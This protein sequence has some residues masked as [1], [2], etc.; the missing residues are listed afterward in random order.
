MKKTLFENAVFYMVFAHFKKVK[1]YFCNE[2]LFFTVISAHNEKWYFSR[3]RK[4]CV[5][6][7]FSNRL[8][9]WYFS[10]FLGFEE[11]A[12][13]TKM[14]MK[15]SRKTGYLT[16]NASQTAIVAGLLV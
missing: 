2:T 8:K 12:K 16:D 6:T 4:H 9:K 15:I 1:F 3:A 11:A 7:G 13:T 14:P 10:D 5:F